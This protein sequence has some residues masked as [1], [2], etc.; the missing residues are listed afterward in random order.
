VL[1]RR[2]SGKSPFTFRNEFPI[3]SQCRFSFNPEPTT[4]ADFQAFVSNSMV[5]RGALFAVA[6]GSEGIHQLRRGTR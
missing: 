6:A 3:S 4:T 5:R 1:Y 2:F